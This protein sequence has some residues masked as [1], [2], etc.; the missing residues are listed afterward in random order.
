LVGD[1]PLVDQGEGV[2]WTPRCRRRR[3]CCATRPPWLRQVK[4]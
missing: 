4:F 3:A 2:E 1:Q